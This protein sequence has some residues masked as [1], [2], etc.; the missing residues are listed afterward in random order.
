MRVNKDFCDFFL[1]GNFTDFSFFLEVA[2]VV[3]A[4]YD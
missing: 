4:D 1:I 2:D 3:A